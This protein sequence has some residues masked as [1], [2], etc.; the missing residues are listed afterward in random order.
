VVGSVLQAA[1]V[2]TLDSESHILVRLA[3]L[4]SQNEFIQRY[5]D[6]GEDEFDGKGG[7][8]PQR[9]LMMNGK[10]V[11]DNTH[12]NLFNASTQIGW[13]A[14]DDAHAV[15]AAYLTVLTRRPSPAEAEHFEKFLADPSLKRS[16][17]LE[18]LCW[19]LVNSTEFSWN[20]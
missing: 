12:E 10:V 7:T 1:S 5:G 6:S 18:D 13:M 2:T 16:E 4:G 14:P 8:I 17:R 3:R 15:E 11:H 9:L 19:A 20:H